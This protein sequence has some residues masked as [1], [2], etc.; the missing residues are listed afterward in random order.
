MPGSVILKV[1]TLDD[2]GVFG[3][4]Q[5]AIFTVDKQSFHHIPDGIPSFERTPG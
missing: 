2:P 3:A 4:P 5:V 1:G